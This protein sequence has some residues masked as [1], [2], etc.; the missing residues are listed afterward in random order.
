MDSNSHLAK[1]AEKKSDG[2]EDKKQFIFDLF[3]R[4]EK[5]PHKF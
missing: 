4:K 5:D 1:I 3:E 2:N